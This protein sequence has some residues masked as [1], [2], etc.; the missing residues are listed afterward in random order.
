MARGNSK[1]YA[2]GPGEARGPAD[3]ARG[4]PPRPRPRVSL[5]AYLISIVVVGLIIF[6]VMLVQYFPGYRSNYRLSQQV[7]NSDVKMTIVIPMSETEKRKQNPFTRDQRKQAE[8]LLKGMGA[9]S[10]TV[11]IK[12][13]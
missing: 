8:D 12:P 3:A 2:Y 11:E 10:A 4:E 1:G 7:K 9:K 5:G 13:Q 6:I